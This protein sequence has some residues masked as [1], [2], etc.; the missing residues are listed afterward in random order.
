MRYSYLAAIGLLTFGNTTALAAECPAVD[1]QPA[2]LKL[3]QLVDSDPKLK[4]DLA[5]SIAL[6]QRVNNDPNSNPVASIEDYYDFVDALTTYNPQNIR[7]STH[8]GG[9]SVAM[10]GKNYCNWNILDIL[11]YSY[12]LVDRQLTTDPRGQ[13]QFENAEFSAWMRSIAE[14]WGA[15]LTTSDSARYVP[16][17]V[18]DPTFGDWYCPKAPYASFQDFFTRELCATTFTNGSRPVEGYSDL[19]TVASVADSTP[20]GWWPISRDGKIVTTYDTVSQRRPHDQGQALQR[21]A[22][23]HHRRSRRDRAL[24]RRR[25]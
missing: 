25:D 22:H 13:I 3:Q 14:D 24:Q 4:A 19:A 23:L 6:G 10:D 12:F 11:A 16:D 15:Y 5:E 1:R 17:F 8:D 21:R 20:A 18:N 2:T 7:T 9:I